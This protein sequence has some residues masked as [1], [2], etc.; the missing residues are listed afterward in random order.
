MANIVRSGDVFDELFDFRRDFDGLFN[1]FLT[2]TAPRGGQTLA[3]LATVPPIEVRIDNS[4]QMYRIRMALPGVDPKDVQINLQGRTLTISGEHKSGEEKKES[5]YL[6]REFSYERF[7]RVIP[8]PEGLDT[9][10]VN[11]EFGNGVLEIAIPVAA[12]ALSRAVE[13]KT[14]KDSAT[15]EGAQKKKTA[16]A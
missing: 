12:S 2:G 14:A 3:P 7:E 10:E 5:N 9:N 8:L 16:S 15:V 1:R 4:D 11:A 6:Q 13:I